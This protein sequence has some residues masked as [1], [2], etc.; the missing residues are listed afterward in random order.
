MKKGYNFSQS[1]EIWKLI[2]KALVKVKPSQIIEQKLFKNV[3]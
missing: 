1:P 2:F 3:I